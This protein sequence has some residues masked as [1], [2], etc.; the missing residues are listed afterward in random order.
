MSDPDRA[1]RDR[2]EQLQA[3][4]RAL[5][6]E[7]DAVRAR[8]AE[9]KRQTDEA[10]RREREAARQYAASLFAGGALTDGLVTWRRA[11]LGAARFAL[12]SVLVLAV[13]GAVLGTVTFA[14]KAYHDKIV[15]LQE[16]R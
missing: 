9:A 10:R 8:L 14:V 13:F 6:P 16:G 3:E 1:H 2:L 11:A 15:K 12:V 7:R 5:E 4:L